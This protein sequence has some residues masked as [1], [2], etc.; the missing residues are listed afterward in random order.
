MG[1]GPGQL[2]LVGPPVRGPR[3]AGLVADPVLAH[4]GPRPGVSAR[5]LGLRRGSVGPASCGFPHH[6]STRSTDRRASSR[7]SSISRSSD[8]DRVS[9]MPGRCG[10]GHGSIQAAPPTIRGRNPV[11]NRGLRSRSGNGLGGLSTG[12][13][14]ALPQ[15]FRGS[16][17][18]LLAPQPPPVP[19]PSRPQVGVV[20][21]GAHPCA[22]GRTTTTPSNGS[23][24]RGSVAVPA[25][26][27]STR[28]RLAPRPAR[29]PD[30]TKPTRGRRRPDRRASLRLREDDDHHSSRSATEGLDTRSLVPRSRYSTNEAEPATPKAAPHTGVIGSD[31][32]CSNS[33]V[34]PVLKPVTATSSSSGGRRLAAHHAAL[35]SSARPATSTS[36]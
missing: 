21:I 15:G 27:V 11:H 23:A 28:T 13:F 16:S 14:P 8:R 20:P 1:G 25:A 22:F 7:S 3:C 33:K 18:A 5:P 6:S 10:A 32:R 29:P 17:L 26:G 34:T 36:R 35:Q 24:T 30:T 19:Y 9:P 12:E 4:R 2:G 31:S